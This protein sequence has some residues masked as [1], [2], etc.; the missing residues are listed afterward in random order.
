MTIPW[1]TILRMARA[2]AVFAPSPLDDIA[3]IAISIA[4]GYISDGCTIDG[5]PADVAQGLLR[6][7]IRTG[8]QGLANRTAAVARVRGLVK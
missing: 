4:Q 6:D 3:A 1:N 7:P 5:C 8:E 2:A